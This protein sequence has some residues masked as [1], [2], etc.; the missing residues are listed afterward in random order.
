MNEIN[1]IGVDEEV[2]E[3][4]DIENKGVIHR[5]TTEK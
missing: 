4:K 1:M 3:T 2:G 5:Y